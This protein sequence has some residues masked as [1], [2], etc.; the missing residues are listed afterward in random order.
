MGDRLTIA[1]DAMGG[2][3]APDI[4]LRG[5]DIAR[6]RYPD[7]RFLIF[8]DEAA[9]SPH[10]AALPRLRERSEVR[11]TSD[12][13]TSDTKPS[14][15]L[16]TGRTSSMW[17]AVEAVRDG[18]A[19]SVVSAGN[20][21]ALMA[22]SKFVLRTPK[23]VDRP[24][25]AGMLP[26]SRGECAMLDLGANVECDTENLVQFAVMGALFSKVVLG[27]ERP[28]VGLL[29]VG[30]EELKGN[31][32]LRGA[33]ARLRADDLPMEFRGFIEGNDIPAGTVDVVVTDGF[34]GN[35]ALKTAEGTAQLCAGFLKESFKSSV[36]AM[37]GYILAR[38]ALRKLRGRLDPRRYNGA[39]FLGLNG[40]VVK[41]HGGS[42][43]FGFGNAVCVAIDMQRNGFME[44]M[45][46]EME[47]LYGGSGPQAAV[48]G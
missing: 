30:A 8:G 23:G 18:L 36:L 48:A 44:G 47:R 31:E 38:G 3:R 37:A 35:V 13:I 17:L 10:L 45:R 11:H 32:T 46:S 42:D 33:A 22:I 19:G 29:N 39:V 9:I 28:T 43:D 6:E 24:A 7:V 27:I 16:R 41:S 15:A 12:R 25:I 14:A 5:A 4:V 20:T 1:L 40:I 2:D 34:T 26:T 21:G